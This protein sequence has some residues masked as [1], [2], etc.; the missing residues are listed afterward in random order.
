MYHAIHFEDSENPLRCYDTYTSFGLMSNGRP[1]VASP[2]LK[3]A[4]VDVPGTNGSL[5]YTAALNGLTY[6][7]RTGSWEFYVL[8]DYSDNELGWTNKWHTIMNNLHGQYFDRIWL[9]DES[10]VVS[11]SPFDKIYSCGW[12]YRG[13]ITVN[14]WKSDPQF[15]KVVL[16]YVLEPYKRRD[17]PTDEQE[18]LWD[19]LFDGDSV[20]RCINLISFQVDGTK[21][22]SIVCYYTDALS[23]VTTFSIICSSPMAMQH[24]GSSD[25]PVVFPAGETLNA[26]TL[27]NGVNRLTFSGHGEIKLSSDNRS[28]TSL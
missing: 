1:D 27:P 4:Y 22:R 7:N 15:S 10:V 25:P 18:W 6:Q 19:D 12:Y 5:D 26:F 24:T 28:M 21:Q 3:S 13:R 9:E 14:E 17:R 2:E 11:S 8:N 20:D 23:P 16:N